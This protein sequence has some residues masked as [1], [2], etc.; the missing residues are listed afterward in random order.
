LPS[1]CYESALSLEQNRE[2][3]EKDGIF[4]KGFID[5][6]IAKLKLY[7]DEFLSEKIYGNSDAIKQLVE[8]YLHC[9]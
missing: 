1:S 6:T 9:M 8:N 4:P 5:N 2:Y 7:D 3:F